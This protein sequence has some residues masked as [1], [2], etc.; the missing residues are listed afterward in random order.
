M[1][2]D[3]GFADVAGQW[4]IRRDPAGAASEVL[5]DASR[6]PT[7]WVT[8]CSPASRRATSPDGEPERVV[9]TDRAVVLLLF[10]GGGATFS[11][12]TVILAVKRSS[13]GSMSSSSD[14]T[15]FTMWCSSRLSRVR[16][17]TSWTV[18]RIT[19]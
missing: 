10:D 12:R 2:P 3:L 19:G 14:S 16:S 7:V 6:G 1:T 15:H 17:S 11:M 5:N 8:T 4:A 18:A 9:A 13:F